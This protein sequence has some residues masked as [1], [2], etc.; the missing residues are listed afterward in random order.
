[1]ALALLRAVV[2]PS[3]MRPLKDMPR[4]R[5]ALISLLVWF[6]PSCFLLLQLARNGA[7]V[8]Q[9]MLFLPL[10]YGFA[11]SMW[12]RVMLQHRWFMWTL[13]AIISIGLPLTLVGL[14]F[15]IPRWRLWI[16]IAGLT[17]SCALTAAAYCL[18]LA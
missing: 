10:M 16:L 17:V 15:R 12:L 8:I 3:A 14:M 1:M 13:A 6:V 5:V 11:A 18:L 7:S 2:Q 9:R 4:A